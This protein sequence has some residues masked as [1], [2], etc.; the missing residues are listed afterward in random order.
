MA[1]PSNIGRHQVAAE[2]SR[3]GFAVIYRARDPG[4]RRRV[5]IKLSQLALLTDH[6]ASA[7]FRLK[8]RLP[9]AQ[10]T[11]IASRIWEPMTESYS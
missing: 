10:T 5:A 4:Q 6:N 9:L 3:G 1:I 2:L 7:R 11:Q 8:I